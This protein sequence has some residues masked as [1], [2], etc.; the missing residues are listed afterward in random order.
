[1]QDVARTGSPDK[2]L[3]AGVVVSNV[4]INGLDEFWHTGKYATPQP[5]CGDV[6]EETLDHVQPGRRGWRE[7]HDKARKFIQP[8]PRDRMLVGGV[9]A[10]NQMQGLL[11]GGFAFDLLQKLQL[12][13][14]AVPLLALRDDLPVEHIERS[15]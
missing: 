15:K 7:V 1:M 6:P 9:I 13:F 11:P 12:F 4:F 8:R 10:G 2:W 14:V 3:W 5:F